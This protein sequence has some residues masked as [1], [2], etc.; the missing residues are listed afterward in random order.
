MRHSIKAAF[1]I[2]GRGTVVAIAETT[3]FPVAKQLQA[4]V[5]RPDGSQLSATA[6]KE[7]LLLK[8]I[9]HNVEQEAYLLKGINKSDIPEGSTV[10]VYLP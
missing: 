10:E 2:T 4:T 1:E 3:D 8:T 5:T 9:P 6:F 7:W